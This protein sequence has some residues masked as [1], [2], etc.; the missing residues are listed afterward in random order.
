M[1]KRRL[2]ASG[3]RTPLPPRVVGEPLFLEDL[4][5]PRVRY[6]QVSRSGVVCR[7]CEKPIKVGE[8][9]ARLPKGGLRHLGCRKQKAQPRKQALPDGYDRVVPWPGGGGPQPD[10]G[11]DESEVGIRCGNCHQRHSSV[12][13]VRQCYEISKPS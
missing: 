11:H 2:R 6:V 8:A 10:G 4:P 3:P 7:R 5:T 13:E 1:G 9:A 12:G